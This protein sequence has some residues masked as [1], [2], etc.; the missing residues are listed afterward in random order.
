MWG[1]IR[2][3]TCHINELKEEKRDKRNIN[4]L[5]EEKRDKR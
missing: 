2:F 4:E 5:K 1:V 3:K